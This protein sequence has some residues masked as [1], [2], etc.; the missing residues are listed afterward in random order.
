MHRIAIIG[1]TGMLGQPVTKAFIEQGFEVSLLVRNSRK[2][3]NIFGSAVRIIEGNIKNGDSIKELLHKG[4]DALYLNLSVTSQ[5]RKKDFQPERE[6]LQ[7][8]LAVAKRSSVSHIGYLSSLVHFYQGHNGF[9]WWVFEIKEKAVQSIKESGLS[10]SIFYPST[11]MESFDKGAYRQGNRINLAGNSLFPMY[12]IAGKDYAR[13]VVKA[14]T[15][16]NGSQDYIVQGLEGFTA[17]EA[18]RIVAANYLKGK[19]Y[20]LKL[21]MRVLRF[22]GKFSNTLNYGA[23]IIEALNQYPEKFGAQKT[24]NLLGK[25]EITLAEYAR[26]S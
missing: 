19:L 9:N 24:W 25:P 14:F 8:I 22:L 11:F 26:N 10:Y 18:A 21:P 1:S 7:T 15:I 3:R 13:Q 2:A 23:N 6:G 12:L 16:N 20:I 17:D 5:S 4:Q